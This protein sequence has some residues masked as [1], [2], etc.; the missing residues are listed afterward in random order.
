MYSKE[1][2]SMEKWARINYQ[3]CLPIGKNDKRVTASKAHAKLS[4]KV[5]TEGIVLLKNEEEILPLKKDSKIAIFGKAQFD[6]VKGGGGSGDVYSNYVVNVYDGLKAKGYRIF[7]DLSSYYNLFVNLNYSSGKEIGNFDEADLPFD[8]IARAKDFTDIAVITIC[9]HSKEGEDYTVQGKGFNLTQ[10]ELNMINA[11]K[12]NFSSVI[13]V[14]NTGNILDVSWFYDD[15]KI[16]GALM[17]WQGGLEGGNAIADIISGDVNPSG[18]LVDT[19]A[20]SIEDYPSTKRFYENNDIVEY[21]EDVFVGYRYFETIP[22]KKERVYYPFGYGLSY[23]SFEFS[24][25]K[26]VVKR[27]KVKVT[28]TVKNVGSVS[29]KEVVQLYYK[30]PNGN[31]SK[32]AINLCAFAKTRLIEPFSSQTLILSFK[33]S[34]M[35]SFDD[36]GAIKKS[37]YVLEKGKYEL[38]IGNSIRNVYRV[39]FDYTLDSSVIVKQLSSLVA[40]RHLSRRLLASGEYV[41][42]ENSTA[43]I[44]VY[45]VKYNCK[46][47][48][49]K[50]D[51]IGKQHIDVVD[52]KISLDDF[53]SQLTPD[54]MFEIL[55]N[56][57]SVGV[58]NTGGIGGGLKKYGIPSPMSTDGPAGVRILPKTGIKTTAFPIATMLACTFNTDLVNKVGVLGAKE[59]IENNLSVWLTPGL[60]IHRNPLCGRNFEYYSEDPF[61]S[62]K[63]ASAM[64]KGIQSQKVVATPKHFACNNKETNRLYAESAVSERALR[65]IYLKG[66][67]ICIKEAKPKLLMT[68]YNKLNGA[69]PSENAEL[70]QGI[71]RNEWKYKGLIVTDWANKATHEKELLAGN[72]IKIFYYDKEI[73][74][75]LPRNVLARSVK[76]LLEMILW[77]D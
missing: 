38:F 66:F 62:G 43:P 14:I 46:E 52:G 3:P 24:D 73:V 29:G 77:L 34:D 44:K 67:E 28:V 26:T 8:L 13:A 33:I 48:Y 61:I 18:K 5:A 25:V 64:V 49:P 11:V 70:I 30:A 9:R 27:G 65:E 7:E 17:A 55:H 57:A 10:N 47:N 58:A 71:L 50:S 59:C 2:F 53:I 51:E 74:K 16:K 45:P 1:I 35:A 75:K 69:Y 12:D 41:N 60:N 23:T 39:D 42:V 32:P 63:M 37:A 4:R 20:K 54:E 72:D 21:D 68:S 56:R 36:N 31:I 19:I 40:P 6:Y 76:K 22:N 15:D